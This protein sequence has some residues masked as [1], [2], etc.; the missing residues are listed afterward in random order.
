MNKQNKVFLLANIVLVGFFIGVIFH[1]INANILKLGTPYNTFLLYSDWFMGDLVDDIR[2]MTK[3]APYISP[4]PLVSYFP[5]A[6]VFLF[7]F[8]LIGHPTAAG[9]LILGIFIVF[10]TYLN[11][12]K[13]YCEEFSKLENFKNLFALSFLTYPFLFA[14]ERG[15]LDIIL[16]LLM[17]ISVYAFAQKKYLLSANMLAII[18]AAKPFTLIFLFLFAY[19]KKWKELIWSLAL[20]G[21]LVLISFMILNGGFM[22]EVHG[23]KVNLGLFADKF[24]YKPNYGLENCSSLFGAL[25]L[26]FHPQSYS[27]THLLAK[28]YNLI[29]IFM[30]AVV[31]FYTWTEKVFWKQITLLTLYMLTIPFSIY[32][33]K[34]IFLFIP[35]WLFVN[36]TEKT[37]FDWLYT[38]L[39]GLLLIPKKQ[40]IFIPIK[41]LSVIV[42][43]V[44]MLL[45]IGLIILEQALSAKEKNSKSI[46]Q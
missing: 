1:Y 31:I 46:E 12:K 26:I 38:I 3:L 20:T 29:I 2:L 32:D 30:T 15:N 9:L 8:S 19:K 22:A 10:F 27:G 34:L 4:D 23:L 28:E 7:I 16:V 44:I 36:E 5:L 39:F 37:K 17:T 18:N 6:Y 14:L 42:N 43:P 13:F 40:F 35:I 11:F 21:I 45:I 24:I 41:V 25:K 33:Y